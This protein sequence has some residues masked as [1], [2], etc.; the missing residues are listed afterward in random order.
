[1]SCWRLLFSIPLKAAHRDQHKF[2]N[3][4]Q[5]LL[6]CN[7]RCSSISLLAIWKASLTSW[8]D[9]VFLS[10]R[11]ECQ[12]EFHRKSR[13][14]LVDSSVTVVDHVDLHHIYMGCDQ[15][16]FPTELL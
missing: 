15:L 7:R 8:I 11:P 16:L 2:L 4:T 10:A 5:V 6:C 9:K 14:F 12:I 13:G 1:L 3:E